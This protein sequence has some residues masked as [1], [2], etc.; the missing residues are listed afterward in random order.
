[1]CKIQCL[2]SANVQHKK[3]E[4]L[5]W[6]QKQHKLYHCILL[7]CA[8]ARN[9]RDGARKGSLYSTVEFI[10]YISA[11]AKGSEQM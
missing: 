11:V 1:M 4:N 6:E 9:S 8:L 5:A 2:W 7:P 10:V 3:N